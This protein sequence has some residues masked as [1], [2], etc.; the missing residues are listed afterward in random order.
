MKRGHVAAALA[1]FLLLFGGV[2]AGGTARAV[3]PPVSL[4]AS[5]WISELLRH[6]AKGSRD[7]LG[8]P[9]DP[10]LPERE[11]ARLAERLRPE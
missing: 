4:A 9:V 7:L 8:L 10:S 1:A 3:S 11:I 6:S 5:P 2:C